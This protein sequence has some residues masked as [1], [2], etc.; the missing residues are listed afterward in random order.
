MTDLVL[1][2]ISY[3]FIAISVTLYGII[4]MDLT[5][6]DIDHGRRKPEDIRVPS[7]AVLFGW[8]WPVLLLMLGWYVLRATAGHFV[9]AAQELRR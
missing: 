2:G 1:F 3:T 8:V 6:C 4:I 5:K 9:W 7:L